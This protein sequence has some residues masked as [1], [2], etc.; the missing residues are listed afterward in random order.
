MIFA[1]VSAFVLTIGGP[2]PAGAAEM[3]RTD[4]AMMKATAQ[5]LMVLQQELALIQA[6]IQKINARIGG[7]QPAADRATSSYC[8]S[9]PQSLK[10]ADFAPG[11]CQ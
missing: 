9:I 7:M 5:E 4:K 11:L 8:K 10:A 6:E 3:M 1:L 2:M